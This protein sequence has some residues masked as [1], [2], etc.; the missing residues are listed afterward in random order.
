MG[1]SE[2]KRASIIAQQAA[3]QQ[4]EQV[5]APPARKRRKNWAASAPQPRFGRPKQGG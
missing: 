3:R 1:K 4:A 5:N 2:D